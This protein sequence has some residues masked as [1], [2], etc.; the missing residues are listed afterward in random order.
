MYGKSRF[1]AIVSEIGKIIATAAL[2]V[3]YAPISAVIRYIPNRT[4]ILPKGRKILIKKLATR[5]A[6]PDFII[7]VPKASD[8]TIIRARS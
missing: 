1:T 4:P 7:A 5:S 3:M 2:F 6:A 8:I